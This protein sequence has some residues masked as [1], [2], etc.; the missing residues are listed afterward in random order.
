MF[1]HGKMVGKGF[2]FYFIYLFLYKINFL[3]L[4]EMENMKEKHKRKCEGRY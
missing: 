3:C 1:N 4:D 2:L